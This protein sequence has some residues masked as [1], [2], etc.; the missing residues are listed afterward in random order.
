LKNTIG[1]RTCFR[2][3]KKFS[4]IKDDG[5]SIIISG[6]IGLAKLILFAT[7]AYELM[8][9][10]YEPILYRLLCSIHLFRLHSSFNNGKVFISNFAGLNR[11]LS[12]TSKSGKFTL[13][14][15]RIH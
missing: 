7:V 6:I 4:E 3:A 13:M 10:G 1:Y 11:G 5:I 14:H 8:K 15:W 12:V 2:Y 9:Q